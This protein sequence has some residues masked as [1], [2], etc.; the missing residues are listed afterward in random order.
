MQTFQDITQNLL[1]VSSD[2]VVILV[3]VAI[4]S[5]IGFF[6][7]KS[8]IIAAII[9]FYPAIILFRSVPFFNDVVEK[10]PTNT[11]EALS[12][13]AVFAVGYALSFM[14][15]KRIISAEFPYSR[16]KKTIE[17]I[18]FGGLFASMLVYI[19]YQVINLQK[20]YNFSGG[21]DKLFVSSVVF[22]WLI[23]PLVLTWMFRR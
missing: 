1:S 21:I 16:V 6:Y 5:A 4:G 3:L 13:I 9:A 11:G 19:S 20:I 8:R 14:S 22:W 2:V 10:N 7:G 18:L 17:G 23:I 12:A 15:L